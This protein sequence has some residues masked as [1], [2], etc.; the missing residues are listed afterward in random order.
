MPIADGF[1]PSAFL[2]VA[3]G[4]VAGYAAA[5]DCGSDC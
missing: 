2:F 4:F 3:K 1:L 5:C